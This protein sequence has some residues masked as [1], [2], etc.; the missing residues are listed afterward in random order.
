MFALG[1]IQSRTCHTDHCPTGVAT[2]DLSRQR[3]LVVPNKAERVYS[4]HKNTVASLA[5]LIGAAGIMH[6]NE[7][8]ADYLMCRDGSGKAT[9]LSTQLPTLVPGVLLQTL[10]S[11][12]KNTLPQ[13]YGL[14]WNRAQTSKFGLA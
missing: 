11:S 10:D 3:A 14:Y 1:C 4:F 2:Q 8:T 13:E 7:I 12:T 5:D 6:P 9:P